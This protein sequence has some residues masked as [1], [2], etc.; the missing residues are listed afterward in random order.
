MTVFGQGEAAALD[1]V[2]SNRQWLPGFHQEIWRCDLGDFAH[3]CF[4]GNTGRRGS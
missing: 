3:F 1:L 4:G 2:E